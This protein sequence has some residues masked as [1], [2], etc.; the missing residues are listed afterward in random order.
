LKLILSGGQSRSMLPVGLA[1]GLMTRTSIL[2]LKQTLKIAFFLHGLLESS[3][4]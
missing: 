3:Q 2:Y 4:Q 1:L